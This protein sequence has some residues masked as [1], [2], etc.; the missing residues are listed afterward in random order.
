MLS[1][2]FVK[3]KNSVL[4]GIDIS[5]S[6]V[7]LLELYR[8]NGNLRV[9]SFAIAPLSEGAIV[10]NVIKKAEFVTEALDK[11]L[12]I[13][14]T[15]LRRAAIA[16]PDATAITKVIQMD[17]ALESEDMEQIIMSEADKYIPYGIDDISLDFEILGPSLKNPN[18]VDVLLVASHKENVEARVDAVNA[19]GLTVDI[20]DV[21]S[22]AV[23]RACGL[24]SKKS[25]L[26]DSQQLISI[27]DIGATTTTF[28]VL[29]AQ[30]TIFSRTELFGGQ[31]LTREI[32]QRYGLTWQEAGLAKK[33][34]GLP[35][36]YYSGVLNSFKEMAVIHIRRCLQL[37]YSA[38]QHS[39]INHVFLAGGS[40]NISGLADYIQEQLGIPASIANPFVDMKFLPSV[41]S[42]LLAGDSP[43]LM[44]SCGLALRS[45]D[46]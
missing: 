19:A 9:E 46:L 28:T 12:K 37:F 39:E 41:N 4:L 16:V 26:S 22:Y 27:I 40:A 13:S 23:E 42:A 8:V 24:L 10:D 44:T 32:Q 5:S 45:F 34:G 30:A 20:V 38:S 29:Q 14:G 1:L 6:S 17:A 11:A 35:D 21:E 43:A 18:A 2:P 7:K 3:Q 36:D 15:R 25:G 31:Q 33:K